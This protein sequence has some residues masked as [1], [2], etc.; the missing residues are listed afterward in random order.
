MEYGK[1]NADRTE[2]VAILN[3]LP[4]QYRVG[5][6]LP[7]I[8]D[9]KPEYNP[10]THQLMDYFEIQSDQILRKYNVVELEIVEPEIEVPTE[11]PLWAFRIMM[12]KTGLKPT[13]EYMLN[14]LPEEQKL[15]AFEHYEY[16]NY[17]VRTHPL[18]EALSSQIGLSNKQVDDIFISGSL[19]R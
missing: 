2:V 13:V 4:T 9:T 6:I 17:I 16:G 10:T 15:D 3:A 12:R 19:L 11:I 18:I 5:Y 1:L 7:I 8:N 14:Q